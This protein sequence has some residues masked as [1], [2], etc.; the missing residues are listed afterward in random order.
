MSGIHLF[1][2]LEALLS[3]TTKIASRIPTSPTK[4]SWY[5]KTALLRVQDRTIRLNRPVIPTIDAPPSDASN[6]LE[7][8]YGLINNAASARRADATAHAFSKR[9]SPV[10]VRALPD[11]R[12]RSAVNGEAEFCARSVKPFGGG[13]PWLRRTRALCK[14]NNGEKRSRGPRRLCC[15]AQNRTR[16]ANELATAKKDLEKRG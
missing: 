16:R 12:S 5:I 3:L 13:R 14:F 9:L 11:A 4:R 2:R 8:C 10:N 15:Q 6:Y 7:S 1:G